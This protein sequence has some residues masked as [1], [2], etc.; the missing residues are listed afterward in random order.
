MLDTFMVMLCLLVV[1]LLFADMTIQLRVFLVIPVGMLLV[2]LV[3]G[4]KAPVFL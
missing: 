4:E 3:V 1:E 2:S